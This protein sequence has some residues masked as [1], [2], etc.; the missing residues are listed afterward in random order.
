MFGRV[1]LPSSY[2]F[3]HAANAFSM[4]DLAEMLIG[5]PR[6]FE[7]IAA[8]DLDGTSRSFLQ[9]KH[10]VIRTFPDDEIKF[11][12]IALDPEEQKDIAKQEERLATMLAR[13]LESW[14]SICAQRPSYA[15]PYSGAAP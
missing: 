6:D 9:R 15:V 3:T 10:K 2:G 13:K 8:G 4:R 5:E 12:N 11:Y 1:P 7:V 14:R